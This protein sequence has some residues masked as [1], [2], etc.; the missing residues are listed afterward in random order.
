MCNRKGR[1][2]DEWSATGLYY[3]ALNIERSCRLTPQLKDDNCKKLSQHYSV[4]CKIF[5]LTSF[6]LTHFSEQSPNITNQSTTFVTLQRTFAHCK[7]FLHA[8][9]VLCTLQKFSARCKGSLHAA[10][11]FCTLQKFFS[12]YKTSLHVAKVLCTLQ[13]IFARCKGSLH[14]AKVLCTLQICQLPPL[15]KTYF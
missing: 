3:L 11:V 1:F 6:H 5:F 13:K 14:V 10:K 4:K 7:S 8:A 2:E 15:L 9:K 12:R